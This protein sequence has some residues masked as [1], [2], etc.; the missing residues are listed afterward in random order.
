MTNGEENKSNNLSSDSSVWIGPTKCD[1]ERLSRQ[2]DGNGVWAILKPML[3]GEN[4]IPSV[5]GI[6]SASL[7][8][9]NWKNQEMI[10]YD[11]G[12]DTIHDYYGDDDGVVEVE[13]N[14]ENCKVEISWKTEAN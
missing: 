2:K 6:V 3:E 11:A 9:L 1:D 5:Y 7:L 4:F 12:F 8:R 10:E 14:P 13:T